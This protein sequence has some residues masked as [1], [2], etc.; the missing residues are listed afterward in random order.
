MNVDTWQSA[1]TAALDNIKGEKIPDSNRQWT[2]AVLRALCRAGQEQNFYTC[3]KS[4]D[5]NY[6]EWLWDCTWIKYGGGKDKGLLLSLPLVA[7]SEWGP[8]ADI[9]EDF[10]KLRVA[11]SRLRLMVFN[12][13]K[14]NG[15]TVAEQSQSV[16]EELLSRVRADDR[17]AR[18]VRYLLAAWEEF[19]T[20]AF[21]HFLI[22]VNQ[23][24]VS[25]S[26]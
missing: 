20:P 24:G 3:A 13:F 23:R 21:R 4:P 2:D 5:A 26:W 8:L 17:P 25:H 12:G 7:E 10:D 1:V 11:N 9:E 22:T 14:G 16:A 6:G 19:R 15:E 18:E